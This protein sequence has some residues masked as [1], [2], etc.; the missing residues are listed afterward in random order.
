M[1]S[2]Q[3]VKMAKYNAYL[4]ETSVIHRGQRLR[5]LDDEHFKSRISRGDELERLVLQSQV[6]P[7]PVHAIILIAE[8]NLKVDRWNID[9]EFHI[10]KATGR[11]ESA[12]KVGKV[13]LES[14]K[15]TKELADDYSRKYGGRRI[16]DMIGSIVVYPATQTNFLM[17]AM[18]KEWS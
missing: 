2:N 1:K 16:D 5:D 4:Y 17:A 10:Y 15:S 3:G 14:D 13:K 9:Y 7:E 11:E 12:I 18:L 8:A 6:K